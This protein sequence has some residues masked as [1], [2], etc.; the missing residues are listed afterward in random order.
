MWALLDW[1]YQNAIKVYDW[2]GD[3]YW[4]LVWII[5]NIFDYITITLAGWWGFIQSW[6]LN[7]IDD[8]VQFAVDVRN[9]LYSWIDTRVNEVLTW[10]WEL[11]GN[12]NANI[13]SVVSWLWGGLESLRINLIAWVN[14]FVW[15]LYNQLSGWV[16]NFVNSS[17]AVFG[18]LDVLRDKLNEIIFLTTAPMFDKL[19][20]Q[21]NLFTDS[22]IEF[23]RDP[24]GYIIKTI[25]DSIW[26]ISETALENWMRDYD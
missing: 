11:W 7:R 22:V 6:I 18:W 17:M 3:R 25:A 10:L 21:T 15:E 19:I 9:E 24:R 1:L 4:D 14:S 16:V 8:A 5:A 20:L 13:D 26:D 2:F 23:L 12:L